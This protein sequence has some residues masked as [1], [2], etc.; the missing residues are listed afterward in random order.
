MVVTELRQFAC[1]GASSPD[2]I[3]TCMVDKLRLL[4]RYQDVHV[5]GVFGEEG[6]WLR[7]P[8]LQDQQASRS[9]VLLL[10][11]PEQYTCHDTPL[12]AHHVITLKPHGRDCNHYC[13]VSKVGQFCRGASAA[14][15][16]RRACISLLH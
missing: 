16:H 11:Q 12:V 8:V 6:R 7:L 5:V 15:L 4:N 9:A 1:N 2:W 14:V 10:L 3:I 13:N